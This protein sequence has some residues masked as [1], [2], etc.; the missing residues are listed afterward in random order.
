MSEVQSSPFKSSSRSLLVERLIFAVLP[1]R[2]SVNMLQRDPISLA[3]VEEVHGDELTPVSHLD[4]TGT[5]CM[6]AIPWKS[7]GNPLSIDGAI[8]KACQILPY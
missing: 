3:Q 2:S 8:D 4:E 7:T 1:G 6:A 5:P